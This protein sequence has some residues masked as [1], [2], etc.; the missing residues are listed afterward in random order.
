MTLLYTVSNNLPILV[1]SFRWLWGP[2]A[3]LFLTLKYLKFYISP[4]GLLFIVYG[5]LSLVILQSTVWVQMDEWNR[6]QIFDDYYILFFCMLLFAFFANKSINHLAQIGKFSLFFIVLTL[7]VTN[8][9]LTQEGTIVRDSAHEFYQDY[10]LAIAQRFGTANYGYAQGL[11]LLVPLVIFH[12]KNKLV[13]YHNVFFNYV[14]LFLI[15]VLTIRAQV[16]ANILIFFIL[17]LLAISSKQRRKSLYILI[18][19]LLI[20]GSIIPEGT[21][22]NAIRQSATFFPENSNTRL[23]VID[24]AELTE[25]K[26]LTD[27]TNEV[28]NRSNRYPE[29]FEALLE[30]PVFGAAYLKTSSYKAMGGHLYWMNRLALLG[31]PGFLFF[32]YIFFRS[33]KYV[34]RHINYKLLDSYKLTIFGFVLFGLMKNITGREPF[35]FLLIVVPSLYFLSLKNNYDF[36]FSRP[37]KLIVK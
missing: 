19:S 4:L 1:G 32:V 34:T 21:L 29:L 18:F 15:F 28:S 13:I 33:V 31:I 37:V 8:I 3:I 27:E 22:P 11:V 12:I 6:S 17:F 14:L 5:F 20:I 7:I 23:K 10:R 30:S 16:F 35:L 26:D 25:S 9:I 36:Y 24:F 2:L